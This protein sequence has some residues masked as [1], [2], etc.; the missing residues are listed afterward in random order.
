VNPKKDRLLIPPHYNPA[1]VI[2]NLISP[3]A[4]GTPI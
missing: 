1:S 4:R 3:P 2:Q